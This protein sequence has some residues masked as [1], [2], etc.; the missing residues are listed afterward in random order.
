MTA[1]FLL[2]TMISHPGSCEF[3]NGERIL[4]AD[5][6]R[7]LPMFAVMP[8]DTIVGY[9]PA[10]GSVRVLQGFELKQIAARYGVSLPSNVQACF[11]W[12]MQAL[13]ESATQAAIRESLGTPQARV[14]IL[15]MSKAPVPEGKL[16]FPRSGLTAGTNVDPSTPVTWRGYVQYDATSRFAVWA[17]VRVAATAPRVVAV[18]P[19]A[20]GK[21]VRK[22]QVRLETCDDF[23]LRNDTARSLE[24]VIGKIPRRVIR[25]GLPVLRSDLAEAFLVERGDMVEVTVL[26]GAAQ[27]SLSAVA[28]LSGRQ[29]DVIS[30]RNPRSGKTFRARVEAQGKAIAVIG[31]AGLLARVQ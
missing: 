3:V 6:T 17:R 24:E 10:P 23:P 27:L 18:E 7:A 29:G 21:A 16:T 30:L 9:S 1:W 15:A 4:A 8:R 13:T 25:A 22:E 28:E 11:E 5:L 19:L 2:L 12:R 14:E 20:A 31:P 26:S